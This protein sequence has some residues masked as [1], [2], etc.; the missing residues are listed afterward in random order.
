M[1][2]KKG[3]RL[4]GHRLIFYNLSP[5]L[6]VQNIQKWLKYY[7]L[8]V[9]LSAQFGFISS[10]VLLDTEGTKLLFRL[11]SLVFSHVMFYD[12]FTTTRGCWLFIHLT[13]LVF[14]DL[15]FFLYFIRSGIHDLQ[16]C[17]IFCIYFLLLNFLGF[18]YVEFIFLDILGCSSSSV[19]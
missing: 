12:G 17:Y 18:T 19:I 7:V 15:F 3:T 16:T 14:I 5:I 6:L 2:L 13:I 1:P 8:T 11:M 4:N 10:L 9:I